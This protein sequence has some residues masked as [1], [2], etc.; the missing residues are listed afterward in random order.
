MAEESQDKYQVSIKDK[1]VA[2]EEESHL[3]K[4]V[5][6]PQEQRE[7]VL[8]ERLAEKKPK[9]TSEIT[10]VQE[11]KETKTEKVADFVEAETGPTSTPSSAQVQNQIK[12]LKK[13]DRSNQVKVLCDLAFQKGLDFAIEVAKSLD[14]AYVLDKLHDT[15]VDELYKKLVE[16]GELKQL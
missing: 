3:E 5:P 15:L 8:E 10:P 9:T 4:K 12:E 14:N 7:L 11:T 1:L 13:M 6:I 2:S 16:K